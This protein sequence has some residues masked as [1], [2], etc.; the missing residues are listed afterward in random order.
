MWDT[1]E[2]TF[3]INIVLDYWIMLLRFKKTIYIFKMIKYSFI[4]RVWN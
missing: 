3:L 1:E 2:F 4:Q